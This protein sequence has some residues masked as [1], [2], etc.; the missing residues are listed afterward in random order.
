MAGSAANIDNSWIGRNVQELLEKS[1]GSPCRV[2]NDAD[3]AGL[4]EMRFGA[5]RGEHG[6]VMIL[7]L[8]TGIGSALF[9]NGHL[10]PNLEL[11]HLSLGDISAEKYAS[12]AVKTNEELGWQE[13]AERLNTFFDRV[14]G[15]F[16]PD[17]YIIGG[18]VSAESDSFFSY[19]Q[20]KAKC[21]PARFLNRAGVVGAAFFYHKEL[22]QRCYC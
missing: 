1:V 20:V 11:G 7:T 9:Y 16:S 21:L 12:A 3:A 6:S 8:G 5:G 18:A 13:W 14:E 2:V 10:F 17:C 15:L 22:D 4:A 19:L